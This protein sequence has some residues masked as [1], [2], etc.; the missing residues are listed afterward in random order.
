MHALPTATGRSGALPGGRTRPRTARTRASPSPRIYRQWMRCAAL[1]C[2]LPRLRS[3]WHTS[4][5]LRGVYRPVMADATHAFG[6]HRIRA[7]EVFC[8]TTLSLGFVNLKPVVP[9]EPRLG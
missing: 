1:H 8:E 3:R 9:G 4:S 7:S 2:A 6:P 5:S